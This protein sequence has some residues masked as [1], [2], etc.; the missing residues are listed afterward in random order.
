LHI[1]GVFAF[2]SAGAVHQ[3]RN[4][5][6]SAAEEKNR[7]LMQFGTTETVSPH[8]AA[9]ETVMAEV[10]EAPRPKTEAP[11]G[12]GQATEIERRPGGTVGM[13]HPLAFMHQF[14]EE[15]D[16]LFDDFGFR[17]PRFVGRGREMLRRET[18]L[19][20][21]DWSPR[22][23]IA[24]REGKIHVRAELPGMSKDDIHVDVTDKLMTIRGERKQ[25]KKEDRGGYAYSECSYGSFYRAIPLPEGVEPGQATAEFKDGVIEV[26]VPAPKRAAAQPRRVQIQDKK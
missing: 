17:M 9:K 12:Q 19:I 23:E 21:A 14:A 22:I 6:N 3:S 2:C 15:M 24:E 4:G 7:R 5:T 18:G 8:F 11:K 25:E 20:S 13:L 10:K 1:A 26:A 16:R